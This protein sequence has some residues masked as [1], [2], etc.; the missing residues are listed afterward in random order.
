MD[1]PTHIEDQFQWLLAMARTPGWKAH[2]WHRA[3]ELAASDAMYADLPRRL[4]E[5]MQSSATAPFPSG[6][7]SSRP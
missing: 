3:Q 6:K 5:S 1:I 2:A 4:K 7:Q